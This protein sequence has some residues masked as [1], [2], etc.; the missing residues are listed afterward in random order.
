MLTIWSA[1]LY[2]IN[3][4]HFA[5]HTREILTSFYASTTTSYF[6][7]S[8][9]LSLFLYLSS[10]F[11][12]CQLETR[13]LFTSVSF[14][15][16]FCQ[17]RPLFVASFISPILLAIIILFY[18]PSSFFVNLTSAFF[19]CLSSINILIIHSYLLLPLILLIYY[20]TH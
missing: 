8:L 2:R 20:L 12:P 6:L 4:T 13:S 1:K 17:T 18:L 14:H 19:T 10:V 5:F 11:R 16:S 3:K 15:V 7:A 9:P